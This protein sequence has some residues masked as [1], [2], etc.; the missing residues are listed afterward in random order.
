[1]SK[2]YLIQSRGWW[3]RGFSGRLNELPVLPAGLPSGP[4][5]T[6][7]TD[8][9]CGR[10]R[11][12]FTLIELLVVIA[13]IAIL[14]ALLLPALGRARDMVKRI[15][16]TNNM[17]QIFLG[18]SI[19]ADDNDEWGLYSVDESQPHQ[20]K[21]AASWI[22][23]FPSYKG[24]L[25]CPG[26][27]VPEIHAGTRPVATIHGD[28]LYVPYFLLFATRPTGTNLLAGWNVY[29]NAAMTAAQKNI[30][31]PTP[32]RRWFNQFVKVY[33]TTLN[34][35]QYAWIGDPSEQAALTDAFGGSV[36]FNG[37]SYNANGYWLSSY[38][39]DATTAGLFGGTARWLHNNHHQLMGTN[40]TFMDGSVLWKNSGQTRSRYTYGRVFW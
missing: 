19:Y 14:A 40:I 1:M 29:R 5:A 13:I 10:Q 18:L 32:N 36:E 35:V 15:S 37:S 30:R 2:G 12:A 27:S 7:A 6:A 39:G 22:E 3:K 8:K 21:N 33:P 38:L 20:W 17:K 4:G 31:Q 11:Q 34:P 26:M 23:Y 24:L 16:C 25:S 9:E 28:T